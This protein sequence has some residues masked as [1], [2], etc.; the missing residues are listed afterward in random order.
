MQAFNHNAKREEVRLRHRIES[1][2]GLVKQQVSLAN[3]VRNLYSIRNLDEVLEQSIQR[4]LVTSTIA[5]NSSIEP[6]WAEHWQ[7][8]F[9]M[10]RDWEFLESKHLKSLQLTRSS[11]RFLE[12]GCG[13]GVL[14][15]ALACRGIRVMA[16]DYASDA[17]LL[18]RL[19]AAANEKQL[20]TRQLD[21]K[22]PNWSIKFDVI[23]AADIAYDRKVFESINLC[24]QS[25][26]EDH[27]LCIIGEPSRSMGDE[28][29]DYLLSHRWRV[30]IEDSKQHFNGSP[31]K[32]RY[33]IVRNTA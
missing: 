3:A 4:E 26:L 21:W 16:T 28:F 12:I 24:L 10:D 9:S 5:H 31:R 25:M 8:A 19:N 22:R 18:T 13:G 32:V 6:Y 17:L 27:G 33:L 15:L 11:I 2:Y 7:S 23:V 14:S 30:V 20:M 1:R 29:I